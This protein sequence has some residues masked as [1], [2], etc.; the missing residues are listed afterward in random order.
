MPINATSLTNR[1]AQD[2]LFTLLNNMCAQFM[3]DLM[4]VLYVVPDSISVIIGPSI[5]I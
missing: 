1:K 4:T 5:S 3:S 2:Q